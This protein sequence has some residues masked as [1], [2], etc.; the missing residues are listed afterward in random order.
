MAK[1]RGNG[2]GCI[3]KR[4]NG[5]WAAAVSDGTDP[6]TGKTKRKFMYGKTREE[7][8]E[9]LRNVQNQ[10][11]TGGIVDAGRLNLATWITT[12]CN[13]YAKPNIKQ[14]TYESYMQQIRCHIIPELGGILLK[15]LTTTDI[16]CFYNNL[17]EH[18]NKAK[19]QDPETG[20]M[21]DKGGGLAPSTIVRIHNIL[22]EAL[23]QAKA[24]N[25]ILVNPVA[26][27]KPPR[28]EKKEMKVLSQDQV[29]IFL[30]K[31]KDYRYYGA[32][33]LA[34]TSGMRRGEVLGLPWHN[35]FL[36]HPT[37][38][39][40]WEK[41][42]NTI[43]WEKFDDIQPWDATAVANILT[44]AGVRFEQPRITID[45]QLNV[46]NGGTQIMTPKTSNSI[47]VIHIPTGTACILVY[48]R[49]LQR[50][51][52]KA[53][54]KG[55]NKE[56]LVF[57]TS[58]G[59]PAPPR[60]FT[61]NFQGALKHAGLE[62]IRF[63]D[64]RHTVATVLLEEGAALNT[65]QELLGHYDPKFTATQYGHVTTR[66]RSEATDKLSGLLTAAQSKESHSIK[67]P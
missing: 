11:A 66:M 63:H 12:W 17:L 65:V 24:E 57:C 16:Q 29:G 5:G 52:K 20:D 30:E 58:T 18:G 46:V 41:I 35:F 50:K 38:F 49:Y 47:R 55:Y 1:R 67:K 7:V 60:S 32:Y 6:K 42:D 56:D 36:H 37:P 9:K 54:G 64:I 15:R 3:Y 14:S 25:K 26:A 19:V 44:E 21:V 13:A 23:E 28:P 22:N 34:V 10:Q 31:S 51:E 27:T 8:K 40:S 33:V 2:E 53:V 59:K 62:R 43:P 61:R 39:D 48:Q 4:K 45:Q